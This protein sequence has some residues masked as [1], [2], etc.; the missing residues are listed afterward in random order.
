MVGDY[1]ELEKILAMDLPMDPLLFLLDVFP[2]HMFNTEQCY[3]L[4]VLLMIVRK[5]ITINWMKPNPLHP[6]SPN[7]YRK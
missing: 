4:H 5:M 1:T 3:I 2:G 6:R 7:G